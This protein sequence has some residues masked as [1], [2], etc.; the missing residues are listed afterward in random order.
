MDNIGIIILAAGSSSR[1]GDIKQLS[2]YQ[3]KTFINHAVSIAK[4]VVKKVI[5]VLGANAEK[6]KEEIRSNDVAF[7]FNKYWE[8]GM[9]SS[10]RSGLG[11]FLQM[12]PD[13]EAAILMVCDQPF[14]SSELLNA[15]IKKHLQTGKQIIASAYQE[16]VGTPV[17]FGKIFFPDLLDLRGQSGAKKIIEQHRDS[18]ITVAFPLGYVDIDTKEDYEI[19]QKKQFNN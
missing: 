5:V 4:E 16:T 9:A 8:E 17:L 6:V 11:S 18:I 14:V 10:I 13:A 7:I 3:D 1:F 15:M 12:N 19:L 2:F